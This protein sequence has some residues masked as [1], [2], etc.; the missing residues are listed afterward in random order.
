MMPIA[1]NENSTKIHKTNASTQM[2][3][4]IQTICSIHML[5]PPGIRIYAITFQNYMPLF[6]FLAHN[7]FGNHANK[8]PLIFFYYHNIINLV[9]KTFLSSSMVEQPAVNR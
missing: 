1:R 9:D 7:A 2:N 6:P 8:L 3:I 5:I 4:I